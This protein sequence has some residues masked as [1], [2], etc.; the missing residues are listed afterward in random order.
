MEN[1]WQTW[2]QSRSEEAFRFVVRAHLPLVLATARRRTNDNAALAEDISQLVFIDLARNAKSLPRG[3][4]LAGWLYRHTCFTAAKAMRSERRRSARERIAAEQTPGATDAPLTSTLDDLLEK[5]PAGDRHALLLR[6]A[7]GRELQSVADALGISRV[8]AQKRIERALARIREKMPPALRSRA[9][10]AAGLTA[11][12]IPAQ[13]KTDAAALSPAVE[14]V[15][16]V[17]GKT[18]KTAVLLT[19][20]RNLGAMQ[21][22]ALGVAVS[23]I[24]WAVPVAMQVREQQNKTR[25]ANAMHGLENA[26][27]ANGSRRARVS[28][29]EAGKK[30]AS[31]FLVRGFSAESAKL[32][33]GLLKP[34]AASERFDA[35]Q[36]MLGA[37]PAGSARSA[38]VAVVLQNFAQGA[39]WHP[40]KYPDD[41]LAALELMPRQ[42]TPEFDDI[43]ANHPDVD[44]TMRL[45]REIQ[46]LNEARPLQRLPAFPRAVARALAGRDV[47]ESLDFCKACVKSSDSA[48]AL[49]GLTQGAAFADQRGRLWEALATETDR[50]FQ[51]E[52]LAKLT[53]AA[54]AAESGA[55]IDHLPPGKFRNDAATVLA[56]RQLAAQ[57]QDA[58]PMAVNAVAEA[59]LS[60]IPAG[61]RAEQLQRLFEFQSGSFDRIEDFFRRLST[62]FTGPDLDR[63]LHHG[64]SILASLSSPPGSALEAWAKIADPDIRFSAACELVSRWSHYSSGPNARQEAKQW[65]KSNFTPEQQEAYKMLH[66]RP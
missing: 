22:A 27:A 57:E 30:M 5:L 10:S 29:E 4:V 3:V 34:V 36:A 66:N 7:E 15:A 35:V 65:M 20:F 64:V 12:L 32:A 62:E 39:A 53:E 8:A 50:K 43:I 1:P 44:A 13:T 45:H 51:T 55:V 23:V 14:Q 58:E 18:G 42:T 28:A 6:F 60:R 63:L 2:L 47:R 37:L 19:F 38:S 11:L 17:A 9:S 56:R 25:A 59:W 21:S 26:S 31:V 46:R 41:V 49:E 52:A 40:K 48:A 54:P 61:E 16:L 33:L 24:V